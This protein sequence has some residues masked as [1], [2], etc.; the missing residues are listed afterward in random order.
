MNQIQ[1]RQPSTVY[2]LYKRTSCDMFI[3]GVFDDLGTAM[4]WKA[5]PVGETEEAY[6]DFHTFE[7][8]EVSHESNTET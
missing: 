6:Y 4:A 5:Q 8:N 2:V 1:K 7:L 3:A